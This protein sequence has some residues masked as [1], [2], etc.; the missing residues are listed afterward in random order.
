MSKVKLDLQRKDYV[1]LLIFAKDHAAAMVGNVNYGFP[2]PDS[3]IFDAASNSY[4]A[5]LDE[6]SATE[7]ALQKLRAERDG[8]RMSLEGNLNSRGT[9][10]NEAS[11]GDMAKIVKVGT[12]KLTEKDLEAV[13]VYLQSLPPVKNNPESGKHK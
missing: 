2:V 8:L 9:Y 5:K 7:T 3:V 13:T 12:S 11:G 1:Q 6:I 10:V 4:A